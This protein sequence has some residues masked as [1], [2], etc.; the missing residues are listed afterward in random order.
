MADTQAMPALA[1]ALS[2]VL[3]DG[4]VRQLMQA[5]GNCNQPYTSRGVQNFQYPEQ[6]GNNNG[7]Y[8]GGQWNPS[9]Y[10][11]LLPPAGSP[12]TTELPGPGGWQGGNYYGGAITNNNYDGNSF[13]FPTNQEFALN[14]YYGGPI[15]NVGGNST[16]NNI[17]ANNIT[18]NNITV[19]GFGPGGGGADQPG[20]PA[21]PGGGAPGVGLPGGGGF[22]PPI[23]ILRPPGGAG[24]VVGRQINLRASGTVGIPKEGELQDDCKVKLTGQQRVRV[25]IE[26]SP[27]NF[28]ALG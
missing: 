22:V 21:L 8:S 2:G 7:V 6:F 5:L 25:Q 11:G 4:A 23:I 3:P 27:M 19:V 18:T 26:I 24:G 28:M 16:F 1:K 10:P 9:Q 17:T 12:G 15:M 20:E 13:Y 14:N